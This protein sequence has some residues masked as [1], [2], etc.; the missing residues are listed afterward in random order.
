MRTANTNDIQLLYG[1]ILLIEGY[2]TIR[3]ALTVSFEV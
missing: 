2:C 1:L 3:N